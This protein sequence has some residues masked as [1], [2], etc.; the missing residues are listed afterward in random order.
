MTR[1]GKEYRERL[2][3]GRRVM[4]NG[5]VV[6]DVASH[7][8]FAGAVDS[9]ARHYDRAHAAENRDVMTYP[10]PATG[11]P[12]NRSFLIPRSADDL[13]L[14]AAALRRSAELSVGLLGRNPDHVAS[15]FAGWA[16][17]SDVFARAGAGYAENLVRFYEHLR[18]E[19]LYAVYAIVPPQVDRSKPAHQQSDPHLYAGVTGETDGG[20]RISGAQMLATGAALADYVVVSNIAPQPPGSEDQ[21]IN[22]AIPVGAPGVK[23]YSRRPYASGATSVFDYPL[24]TRFDETDALIVLDDVFVPWEHVFV[25]RDRAVC[26]AQWTETPAHVLGNHQAQV[27]L[28]T[29]LEFAVGLAHRIAEATG[30]LAAPPVRGALGEMAAT[31]S[32]VSGLLA[33][34]IQNREIDDEGIAWPAR[35]ECFAVMT[36]QSELYPRVLHMLRDLCGGGLIQ[37]PSSSADF[38]HPEMAADL[39]RYVGGP[40]ETAVDRVKLL[41]LAWDLIGSEF[42]GRHHQYEM[43]YVGAPFLVKQRMYGVYDFDRCRSLVDQVLGEYG[44]DTPLPGAAG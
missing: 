43:F 41:K 24:S 20:V 8:A 31:V 1:S 5:E 33:A 15:F 29:K 27:R 18:D 28:A 6:S 11:E 19:D 2:A 36:L 9:V 14:R 40:D 22:V 35:E 7:P 12:V 34:Q 26:A 21:A 3:D 38:A 32:V 17:R 37:L 10:S 13:A 25:L 16:A 42:G 23:I 4:V 44:L 30:N 39:E